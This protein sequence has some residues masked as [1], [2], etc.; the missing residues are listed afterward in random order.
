VKSSSLQWSEEQ[1][2]IFW[3]FHEGTGNLVVEAYAG[4]GKTTTIKQAFEHALESHMLYAVFNKKNQREAEAKITDHRVDVKTLHSVG[5]RFIKG[6]WPN[7]KPD[8]EVES[9]RA[10][11]CLRDGSPK[12]IA[13]LCRLVAFVKN[14]CIHPHVSDIQRII[15]EQDI[16]WTRDADL[17]W[18]KAEE[19]LNLSKERDKAGRISFNDMVWLPVAMD[20]V[21]P[22]YDLVVIDEAQDMNLPQLTMAMRASRGRIVVVGDSRQAIY[23]FRGAVQNAMAMMKVKLKAHT[24]SLTTTYRC[25][26]SVVAVAQE[27]VPAY[28]AAPTAP[29][30]KVESINEA[31]MHA[32]IKVGDA[33]LSRL[34]APLMPT[35][36]SLLR[37][38]IPARIEGRDIGK[39]LVGMVKSMRA[40][41][42]PHFIEK[43]ETWQAKQIQRLEGTKNSDK[44]LE[45]VAD[46]A[47]TLKALAEGA[48]SVGDIERRIT[49][50]FQDTDENS[51]PAVVLSSVHKAKGLEWGRVFLLS[52]TFR[53]KTVEEQNIYYVAVTRAMKELYMVGGVGSKSVAKSDGAQPTLNLS[54]TQEFGS[55]HSITEGVAL[56]E[57]SALLAQEDKEFW[58]YES[59]I[60]GQIWRSPGSIFIFSGKRYM[61]IRLNRSGCSAICVD[62]TKEVSYKSGNE[63]SVERWPREITVSGQM[64]KGDLVEK[65]EDVEKFLAER[66]SGSAGTNQ[67]TGETESDGLMGKKANNELPTKGRAT[68]I[69]QL[70]TKGTDKQKALELVQSKFS[71]TP[72]LFK[73][74]WDRSAR[75]EGEGKKSSPPPRKGAKGGKAP[76]KGAKAATKAPPRKVAPKTAP[77]ATNATSSEPTAPNNEEGAE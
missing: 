73:K 32:T 50:L 37:K 28:K 75:G 70:K 59:C 26:K 64:D 40:K 67:Q 35:A 63:K 68:Y 57:A 20:W 11:S 33:I 9:D 24:L 41:S 46:V 19:V 74:I 18:V 76:A 10:K 65:V 44:K 43:V 3:W 2:D 66:R 51:A 69:H 7:A 12:D 47:A 54:P 21:K 25:P 56:A 17:L 15:Q 22:R 53:N 34:N 6:M 55:S 52:E 61:S 38:D 13:A 62:R 16:Q 30:G 42:V 39:Q 14:M 5:F 49:N 8:D 4:T 77:E 60:S 45:Q 71:C 27:T 58:K 1:S 36:L 29:E 31:K 23:G 48:T 72:G